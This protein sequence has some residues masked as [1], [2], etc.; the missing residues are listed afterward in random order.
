MRK[1]MWIAMALA[2]ACLYAVDGQIL[3]NQATVASAGGFP[4]KIMQGGS[5]KL[6]GNL[7]VSSINTNG[8]DIEADNVT[9]DLNGFTIS[10]AAANCNQ[11]STGSGVYAPNNGI[12]LENGAIAGFR[13]GADIA[14]TRDIVQGIKATGNAIGISA[15]NSI[16][17]QNNVDSNGTGIQAFDCLVLENVAIDNGVGLDVEAD[18]LYGSNIMNFNSQQQ[19]LSITAIS[20]NNNVCSGSVC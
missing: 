19:I 6:S 17:K 7:V 10:C 1:A 8:I 18:S 20:Q 14:G 11:E 15:L 13:Y 12:T 4:Y 16:V 9:L 3:V 5:Y 2:P